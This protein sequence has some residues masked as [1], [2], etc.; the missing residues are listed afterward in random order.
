MKQLQANL[1]FSEVHHRIGAKINSHLVELDQNRK[2]DKQKLLELCQIGKMLGTYFNEFEI[3]SVTEKPDFIITNGEMNFG[4]EHE[5]ILD[6]ES[7]A[8][9]GFYENICEKVQDRL[10]KIDGIP[11]VLVNLFFKVDLNHKIID[12][13]GIIESL[14]QLVTHF[15]STNELVPNDLVEDANMMKHSQIIVEAN[16]GAFMQS[17]ITKDLIVEH[18]SKKETKL[19]SYKLNTRLPQWLVLVIGGLGDSSF[20]VNQL[21][22]VELVTDFDK[23]Y[24][25]EDFNN[26]LFE[27]K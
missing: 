2:A 27:L 25:Y 24:L 8:I 19:P 15:I 5:L 10:Q 18:V 17:A 21:F 12:K 9:E 22:D 1:T 26:N 13:N 7:K 4:L 3:V 6:S 20:E 11:A 14:A 23:V 16:F